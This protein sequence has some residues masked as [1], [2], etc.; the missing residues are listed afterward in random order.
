MRNIVEFFYTDLGEIVLHTIIAACL[1]FL[2]KWIMPYGFE[3]AFDIL[4]AAAFLIRELWQHDWRF[5]EMGQQS[6]LEFIIPW[7]FIVL[8]F[9]L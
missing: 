3:A 4:L 8:V 1:A 5:N 9:S 2:F 7:V 6:Y